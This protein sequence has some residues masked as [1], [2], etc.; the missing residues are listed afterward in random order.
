M[1]KKN[2]YN[3]LGLNP[4]ATTE[5]IKS[6]YRK[7][8]HKYH[9]DIAGNDDDSIRRFK[10][11]TEAYETL[12]SP[13]RREQ[14]D[15]IMKLYEY[16]ETESIKQ[17]KPEEKKKTGEPK[18]KPAPKR[19]NTFSKMREQAKSAHMKNIFSNAINNM[20]KSAKPKQKKYTPPKVDG[21]DITTEVTLSITEAINGTERVVNILHLET[22]DK[23]HGRKFINGS[24]CPECNGSGEKS[25]YKKLTVKIPAKVRHNSKI[26]VEGEGNQGFNGG[27]RGD[28]YLHI[29]IENNVEIQYDGLNVLRTIPIEP[30]EAVLGGYIDI[31]MPGGNIQMKLM[32]NT[33]NGQKYRLS[34]QG[35]EKDGK[36]G[37]LIITVKIDIP[38][39]L[40]K[41]EIALY[42]QLKQL[43]KQSI[44]EKIND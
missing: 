25:R 3:I 9:P 30:Y 26:R 39:Q 32:P 34:E 41:A 5:E 27:K 4:K 16:G 44:R 33:Y 38:K 6:A 42:E 19:E 22:C 12:S 29:K 43:S 17:K 24:L 7:L 13:Q 37:D 36:K 35:V 2:Y 21:K 23:C 18:V 14:Y 10:D 11:I 28:L 15:S 20:L 40:S 1:K 8:V 31:E